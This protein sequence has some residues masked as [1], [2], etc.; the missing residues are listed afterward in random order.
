MNGHVFKTL[1][2]ALWLGC[3]EIFLLTHLLSVRTDTPTKALRAWS[4]CHGLEH[5]EAEAQ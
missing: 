5:P 2:F 3:E 4:A 1:S